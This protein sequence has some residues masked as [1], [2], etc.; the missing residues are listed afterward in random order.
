MFLNTN[1]SINKN[2]PLKF[3]KL[4]P[5]PVAFA[6]VYQ[7]DKRTGITYAYQSISHWDKEKKQSRAKRTLIGRVVPVS[8]E[9]V[10]TRKKAT[11]E[12]MNTPK[13]RP[14]PTTNVSRSFYGATY[15]LDGIGEKRGITADLKKC[16]PDTFK[17]ILSTAYYLLLEEKSPL[18]RFSKWAAL[19]KHPYGKDIPSQRS[20]ELFASIT[21]EERYNFF[22]LQGKR[23]SEKEY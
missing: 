6:I 21:E 1:K 18:S 8:G 7:T 20:S 4:S 23:R 22:H 12:V 9:V 5:F 13:R 15:L 11:P 17:Q 19:H 16:F 14:V 2:L 3:K 10:P